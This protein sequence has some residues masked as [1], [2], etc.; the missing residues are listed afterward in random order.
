MLFHLKN[1]MVNVTLYDSGQNCTPTQ[2]QPKHLGVTLDHTLFFNK[3]FTNIAAKHR[4]SNHILRKLTGTSQVTSTPGLHISAPS[5]VFSTAEYCSSVWRIRQQCQQSGHCY[6]SDYAYHNGDNKKH[7][8]L[9]AS[10]PKPQS[11]SQDTP[12]TEASTGIS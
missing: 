12:S 4:T 7:V 10:A 6:Q 1:R 8:N 3:Q 9:L 2:F 5:L 11:A